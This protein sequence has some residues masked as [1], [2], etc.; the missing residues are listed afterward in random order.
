LIAQGKYPEAVS[1]LSVKKCNHNLGLAQL[2]AG[3]SQAAIVTLKCAPVSADT[4]YLLAIAAARTNDNTLLWDNLTKAVKMNSALKAR[5][6]GDREFIR[7]FNVP[8][9]QAIVK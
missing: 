2:L 7:F 3:N 8:E 1:A 5:A 6:A 9:F 4:Y